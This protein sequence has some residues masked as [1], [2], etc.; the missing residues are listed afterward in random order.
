MEQSRRGRLSRA[1]GRS[2][3]RLSRANGREK[4]RLSRANGRKDNYYLS[5][6]TLHDIQ[7]KQEQKH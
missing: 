5:Y 4:R 6:Y 3:R 1:N 2:G 7:D